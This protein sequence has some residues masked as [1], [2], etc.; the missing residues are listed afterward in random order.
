MAISKVEFDG[1]TLIDLST[2][3]VASAADI[4]FGKIGHLNDG[5]VVTGTH[6]G[7][8]GVIGYK[9]A[10]GSFTLDED[11]LICQSRRA[12]DAPEVPT[13]NPYTIEHNLGEVPR[14]FVVWDDDSSMRTTGTVTSAFILNTPATTGDRLQ[15]MSG[16][17]RINGSTN[18]TGLTQTIYTAGADASTTPYTRDK[19]NVA[20][21][22]RYAYVGD[23]DGASTVMHDYILK[24]GRTYKWLAIADEG[25]YNPPTALTLNPGNGG[26]E[27]EV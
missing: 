23:K 26:E 25:W 22:E 24:A 21:D 17:Y 6:Q 3:T 2:D 20:A 19:H 1:N 16:L 10:T 5:T 7:G 15:I 9:I 18:N 8:G 27:P 14:F 13:H 12:Q 4:A 11:K